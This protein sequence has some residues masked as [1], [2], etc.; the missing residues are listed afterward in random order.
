[1]KNLPYG[2]N[3]MNVSPVDPEIAFFKGSLTIKKKEIN[4]SKTYSR[5]ARHAA[6]KK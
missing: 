5:R 1:M 2:E 4:A 3:L 6:W